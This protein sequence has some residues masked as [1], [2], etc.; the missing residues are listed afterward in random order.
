MKTKNYVEQYQLNIDDK[1]SH[2]DFISDLTNEFLVLLEFNK[3]NDN[4]KGFDNAVRAIRMKWD[5][6]NNK[7]VGQLPDKLWNYFFA[8]VVVK[9]REELCPKDMARRK[10]LQEAQ[11]LAAEQRKIN[12]SF[13]DSFYD[14][15]FKQRTNFLL[16]ILQQKRAPFTEFAVLGFNQ[17]SVDIEAVSITNVNKAYR[18]MSLSCHPDKGGKQEDFILLTEARNKCIQW[19]TK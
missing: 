8:T 2:S 17:D 1:F 10:E 15:F 16:L 5:A 13:Y 14:D 9:L 4:I 11:R 7:T 19:L 18:N 6:I 3:A 12:N